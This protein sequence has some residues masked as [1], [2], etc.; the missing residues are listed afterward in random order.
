MNLSVFLLASDWQTRALLRAELIER[1]F[2]VWA[3]D[4]WSALRTQLL[5]DGIP[6]FVVVDL[7]DL[8]DPKT[9]LRELGRFVPPG[10]VLV[11][12]S[13]GTLSEA[14]VRWVG[15]LPL[16]RP[17]DIKS[18]IEAMSEREG[19]NSARGAANG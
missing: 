1:G 18:V 14:E 13:S 11:L 8:Q 9:I 19:G 2:D 7:K 4:D 3:T 6:R 5:L 12:T 16:P 10:R 17:V 15:M